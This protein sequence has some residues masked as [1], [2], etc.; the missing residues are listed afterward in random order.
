MGYRLYIFL[1]NYRV[2]RDVYGKD[3]DIL[4]ENISSYIKT[5]LENI[6]GSVEESDNKSILIKS[7][8]SDDF[9][10]TY[11]LAE[12]C[13]AITTRVRSLLK[14]FKTGIPVKTGIITDEEIKRKHPFRFNLPSDDMDSIPDILLSDKTSVS[15][16]ENYEIQACGLKNIWTTNGVEISRLKK[17]RNIYFNRDEEDELENF[18]SDASDSILYIWGEKGSGKSGII[19]EVLQRNEFPGLIHLSE[20]KHT[21]R[22]FRLVHELIYHMLFK[23]RHGGP[24]TIEDVIRRIDNSVLPPMNRSNIIYFIDQLFGEND[25]KEPVLFDYGTYRTS[26]KKALLDCLKLN[27]DKFTVIIDDHQWVSENCEAMIMEMFSNGKDRIK[28]VLCS[29]DKNN[30][31]NPD[32]PVR[33]LHIGDLNKVQISKMLKMLFPRMKVDAKA[34]DFIHKATGGNLYTVIEFIQYLTDKDC[35]SIKDGRV[36]INYP[37]IKTMPDNLN[38]MFQ[39]KAASL[40]KNASDI[41]KIISIIGDEFYPSDLDWLLHTLNYTGNEHQAIRELEERGIIRN[42]GDHFSVAEV[43]VMS[44]IYRNVKESNRKLIHK[45]LGE[46]FETKGFDKFGFKVFLHYLKA[47]NYDKLIELLPEITFKAHTAIQFNAL[48]NI[49]EIADKL[50]F[51]LCMKDNAYP[52]EIWLSNLK[53]TRYLFDKDDPLDTVK[54]FEKAIDHLIK[55]EKSELTLD[56]FPMLLK[57]YI[58]S[59]KSKKSSQYVKTGLDLAEKLSSPRHKL[60]IQVLDMI[61]KLNSKDEA[62]AVKRFDALTLEKESGKDILESE[63]YKYLNAR[64]SFLKN[65]TDT[66]HD[67]FKELLEIFTSSLNF[68]YVEEI[69]RLMV[70]IS[71]KKRDHRSAEDYCKYI[72]ASEKESASGAGSEKLIRTNILLARLYGYQNKFLQAVSLLESLN[73]RVKKAELKEEILY[74]LGSIYQFYDEKELAVKTF[75]ILAGKKRKRKPSNINGTISLIKSALVLASLDRFKESL[76]RLGKCEKAERDICGLISS[77]ITFITKKENDASAVKMIKKISDLM[78]VNTDIVFE[79]ALLLL[80]NLIK[81]RKFDLCSDLYDILSE[82]TT[83]VKDYNL[84]LEFNKINRMLH[85]ISKKGKKTSAE[86]KKTVPSVRRRVRT[87]RNI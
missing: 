62:A 23:K 75:E 53:L 10:T 35:I 68:T 54:R 28:L 3:L 63:E 25:H 61:L 50:L 58:S 52:A 41:L 2:M 26:L 33:Y 8:L 84:V 21:T 86:I 76:D 85:R 40:S 83:D 73:D 1:T 36:R 64:V 59:Q 39:E 15:I 87:R 42:E 45:L 57:C 81:R 78:R 7:T 79:S 48:K 9:K 31:S 65:D 46:L 37:D 5:E 55:T 30:F 60:E 12:E 47:E 51:R 71:M 6:S 16:I 70:E 19:K 67:I 17:I 27:H 13:A 82:S 14:D 69:T 56:L 74:E 24:D 29:D 18:L 20:R 32:H 77:V 43:S 80:S 44:E 66:A 4:F 34:A 22:E 38:E 11:A 49:L 72:L